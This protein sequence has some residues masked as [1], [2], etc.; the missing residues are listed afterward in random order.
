MSGAIPPLPEYAFMV[1]CSVKKKHRYN[2]TFGFTSLK[3]YIIHMEA[4]R[5]KCLLVLI[6]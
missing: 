5:R 4:F 1:W 3:W 2:F 6:I